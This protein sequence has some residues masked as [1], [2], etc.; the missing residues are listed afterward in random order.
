MFDLSKR[1][2]FITTSLILSMGFIGVQILESY[3][4]FAIG[5]LGLLTVIFFVWSLWEGLGLNLTLLTLV[6]PILFT[7][8]VGLFWFLLPSSILTRIPIILLYGLGIYALC[9]TANI[10]TVA[11]IRTIALLRAARGVGFV[12][13][14]LTFFLLFNTIFS[15]RWNIYLSGLSIF[16][17]SFPLY[18]QGY[19]TIPLT[20]KKSKF[21]LGMSLIASIVSFEISLALYFWPVT[22]LVGSLFLTATSYMILG[23]GQADLEGRLFVQT[24]REYLVL[25]LLVFL[26]MFFATRWGG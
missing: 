11:T 24:V 8:G 22:V 15:L 10:Y 17:L 1:K 5:V 6:L 25:G 26:G 9:L 20:K 12:L 3:K 19:W 7:I 4:I 18:L 16:C 2:R 21:F 14:L 13:T 23:L